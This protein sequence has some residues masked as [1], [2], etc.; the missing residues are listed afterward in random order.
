VVQVQASPANFAEIA[1]FALL[2][3]AQ[4]AFVCLD[5]RG[6]IIHFNPAA[7]RTFPRVE[8][9]LNQSVFEF[10]S[11]LTPEALESFRRVL[12]GQPS[13]KIE[14][15]SSTHAKHFEIEVFPFEGGAGVFFRDISE[16]KAAAA[17]VLKS[18][19][20]YRLLYEAGQ[21]LSSTLELATIYD[22]LRE[23][24]SRVTPCDG[25]VVSSYN[26][27]EQII[28]CQHAWV[29]G[30]YLDPTQLPP[31]PLAPEGGV[32]MQSRVIREGRPIL[33]GDV[34]EQVKHPKGK[35][36]DV[37]SDGKQQ[38]LKDGKASVTQS[39]LM[40]PVKLE[41]QVRGVVQVMS[42]S[43]NVYEPEDLEILE[44]IVN[45]FAVAIQ[46]AMLYT[47]AKNEIEERERIEEALRKSEGAFRQIAEVMPQI[48]WTIAADGE[49]DYINSRYHE[50]T[51]LGED[52]SPKA[53]WDLVVHPD[54]K[55]PSQNLYKSCFAEGVPWE[56]EIRLKRHDG[57]YRWHLSRQV[58]I[59]D[60]EGTIVRWFATSTDIH[61]LKEA[62]ET[63]RNYNLELEHRV[64]ERTRELESA[65]RDMQHFTYSVSHDL[66]APLR[67]IVS[68]CRLLQED[69]KDSLPPDANIHLQKLIR[70]SANLA[71]LVDDLLRLTRLGKEE[72]FRSEIDISGLAH[73]LAEEIIQEG[74][75]ATFS[76]EPDLRLHA[77]PSLAK[78]LLQNLMQNAT[79]FHE[80]PSKALVH[81]GRE[82]TS[83]FV[84]DNGIG[85]AAEYSDKIFLP[86]ERLY[87]E[88][89]AGTGI[90]L[91]IVQRIAERHG[92]RVWFESKPG[93]GSVFYFTL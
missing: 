76:I 89:F 39:A 21:S 74:C 9:L 54:D 53:A 36:Y 91:A 84:R 85:I 72:V 51:G 32:G 45:T 49:N 62:E 6:A 65:N 13:E 8:Q 66:R 75:L 43:R 40:V 63:I 67:S 22:R 16:P 20:R 2:D 35:F 33:F 30:S 17:Q 77:D 93:K 15:H 41:G 50:Y 90:G 60:E 37:S 78:L 38:E 57:Q 42:D 59:R 68:H 28:R 48:V 27:D 25:L 14:Q 47:Q 29:N 71:R 1:N 11:E 26:P 81:V 55:A 12:D 3:G 7:L 46:N 44:A 34:A 61:E 88:R 70:S 83:I 69:F 92:G 23:L 86:F 24:I 52:I 73:E 80:D 18:N 87:G 5:A 56:Q 79:K 4:D 82:G 31:V 58:P 19:Q 64:A 10:A